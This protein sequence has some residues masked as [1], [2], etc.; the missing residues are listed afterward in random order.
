MNHKGKGPEMYDNRETGGSHCGNKYNPK[1]IPYHQS[2]GSNGG[3]TSHGK[4]GSMAT[5]RLYLPMFIDEHAHHE[6]VDEFV[7]NMV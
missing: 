3:G 7:E 5:P 2:E 4:I 6:H 1:H